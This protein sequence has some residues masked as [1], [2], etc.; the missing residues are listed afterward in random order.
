MLSPASTLIERGRQQGGG[1]VSK[2][3]MEGEAQRARGLVDS[4]LIGDPSS[5]LDLCGRPQADSATFRAR[6]H[7]FPCRS[8]LRSCVGWCL[9]P[10]LQRT[11][12]EYVK[13][14]RETAA[15]SVFSEDGGPHPHGEEPGHGTLQKWQAPSHLEEWLT[16]GPAHDR[17][18]NLRRCAAH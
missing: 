1:P 14:F 11:V 10:V 13:L 5:T 9:A 8:S 12:L 2:G 4:P 15:A 18:Q 7:A 3:V 16:S 6:R 17:P